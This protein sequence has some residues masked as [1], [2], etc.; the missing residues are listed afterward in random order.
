VLQGLL[1]RPVC[2]VL[3]SVSCAVKAKVIEVAVDFNT[4]SAVAVEPACQVTFS[5]Q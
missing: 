5:R 3:G 2:D 4:F 1:V